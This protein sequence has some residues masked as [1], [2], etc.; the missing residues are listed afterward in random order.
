MTDSIAKGV[1]Q[2]NVCKIF[3]MYLDELKKYIFKDDIVISNLS[4]RD[5]S[6]IFAFIHEFVMAEIYP[7]I[8]PKD[9]TENDKIFLDR[10]KKFIAFSENSFDYINNTYT[11]ELLGLF[12]DGYIYIIT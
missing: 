7:Y 8:F 1:D 2:S 10:A 4:E 6:G 9:P 3:Y 11:E 5:K 12:M